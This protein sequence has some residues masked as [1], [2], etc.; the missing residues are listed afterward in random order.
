MIFRSFLFALLLFPLL[1]SPI[2]SHATLLKTCELSGQIRLESLTQIYCEKDLRIAAGTEI[3]TDGNS[4]QILV[5]GTME[6]KKS[7]RILSF[8]KNSSGRH[9]AG[10]IN[11]YARTATGYLEIR[12]G[13]ATAQ[14]SAG[15][16]YLEYMSTKNYDH[17][18]YVPATTRVSLMRNG[19]TTEPKGATFKY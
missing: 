15:A 1:A 19:Y 14:D 8:D 3:V 9:D 13:G 4:L 10:Q 6:I 18:L 5:I 12:N 2:F 16:I 11:V 7:L 17:D